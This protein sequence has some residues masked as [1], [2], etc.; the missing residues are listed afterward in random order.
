MV[1]RNTEYGLEEGEDEEEPNEEI[2]LQEAIDVLEQNLDQL[3]KDS[4]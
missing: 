2:P 3:R 4:E 1:R